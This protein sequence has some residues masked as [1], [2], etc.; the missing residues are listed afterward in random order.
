MGLHVLQGSL[1]TVVNETTNYEKNLFK[2]EKC[3][4]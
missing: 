4:T 2:C 1:N 3:V